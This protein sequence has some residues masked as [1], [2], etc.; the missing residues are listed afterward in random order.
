MDSGKSR[1]VDRGAD[2][3]SLY[4]VMGERGE[5]EEEDEEEEEEED[6]GRYLNYDGMEYTGRH[7]PVRQG[8][9][10]GRHLISDEMDR[11]STR[12][13]QVQHSASL[14]DGTAS[15][16]SLSVLPLTRATPSPTACTSSADD[17]V[18][19]GEGGAY[20]A[21]GESVGGEEHTCVRNKTR[22]DHAEL[23][24]SR[25]VQACR[26]SC[27]HLLLLLLLL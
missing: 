3:V 11:E 17:V 12:H 16:L 8:H 9:Q 23:Q 24:Q 13:R 19:M 20:G 10:H 1:T 18:G 2:T 26:V 7:A 6:G 27:W 15:P 21:V 14:I 5:V 22:D 25:E 4:G